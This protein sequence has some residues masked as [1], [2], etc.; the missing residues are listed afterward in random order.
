MFFRY[1]L[2]AFLWIVLCALLTLLPG[3]SMPDSASLVKG[4]DKIAHI[5]M[6][7]VLVFLLIVGFKKQYEFFFVR[8]Y[9]V[10]FAIACGWI[11]GI[12]IEIAQHFIPGRGFEWNDIFADLIGCILGY[13][14]FYLLYEFNPKELLRQ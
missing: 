10:P 11:Y 14:S 1:N 3:S 6:F 8:H 4:A 12:V 9:A 2:F 7:A 13:L 5:V